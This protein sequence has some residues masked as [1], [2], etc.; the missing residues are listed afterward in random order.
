MVLTGFSVFSGSVVDTGLSD[1]G[2]FAV[3]G[4]AVELGRLWVGVGAKV[5][6]VLD[7]L[8]VLDVLDGVDVLEGRVPLVLELGTIKQI[9]IR[10]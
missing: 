1:D 7:G 5:V 8:D 6:D 9:L 3:V 2:L 4:L 10:I